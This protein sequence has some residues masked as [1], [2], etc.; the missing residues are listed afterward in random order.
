MWIFGG[1][2][3]DLYTVCS[4]V[5]ADHIASIFRVTIWITNE[6]YLSYFKKY[7]KDSFLHFLQNASPYNSGL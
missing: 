5:P 3:L 1:L 7:L 4:D 6:Q 2:V